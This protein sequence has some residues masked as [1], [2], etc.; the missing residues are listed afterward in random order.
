MTEMAGN[1][2]ILGSSTPTSWPL[3]P[4]RSTVATN[5]PLLSRRREADRPPLSVTVAAPPTWPSR[6]YFAALSENSPGPPS[7]RPPASMDSILIPTLIP[8]PIP[9]PISAPIRRTRDSTVGVS[10]P[11]LRLFGAADVGLGDE[12]THQRAALDRRRAETDI[13]D[14]S[15]DRRLAHVRDPAVSHLHMPRSVSYFPPVALGMPS[16]LSS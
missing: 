11:T 5:S 4:I 9:T 7:L 8:T 6:R 10:I 2:S 14:A 3:P 15:T 1:G 16:C 13:R 12:H